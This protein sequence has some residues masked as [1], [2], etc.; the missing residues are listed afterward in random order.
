MSRDVIFRDQRWPFEGGVSVVE[1]KSLPPSPEIH[2]VSCGRVAPGKKVHVSVTVL[3][4][5]RVE[6]RTTPPREL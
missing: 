1:L 5:D 6:D 3:G 2:H 4:V